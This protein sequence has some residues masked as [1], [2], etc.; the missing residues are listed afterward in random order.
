MMMTS[1]GLSPRC[2]ILSTFIPTSYVMISQKKYFLICIEIK[3]LK[4]MQV[5]IVQDQGTMN[6][7]PHIPVKITLC[8]HHSTMCVLQYL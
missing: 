1:A 5:M 4:L 8:C 7:E 3:T 2:V 6:I